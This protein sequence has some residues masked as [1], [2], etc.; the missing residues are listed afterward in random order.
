MV[1]TARRAAAPLGPQ[2]LRRRVDRGTIRAVKG[3]DGLRRIPEAAV[4]LGR[5]LRLA[6]VACRQVPEPRLVVCGRGTHATTK[7]APRAAGPAQ[8]T[9]LDLEG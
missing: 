4:V 2:A 6:A 1:W 3:H 5:G 7:R 8:G 9:Q